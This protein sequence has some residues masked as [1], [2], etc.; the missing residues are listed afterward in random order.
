MWL[1]ILLFKKT[2]YFLS[3]QPFQAQKQ[4]TQLTVEILSEKNIDEP[5]VLGFFFRSTV[6]HHFHV[7][8][9]SGIG[10]VKHFEVV[11]RKEDIIFICGTA[12]EL[13]VTT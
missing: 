4:D 9:E 13:N 7:V 12:D 5:L 6:P 8:F 10:K 2:K 1:C 3:R 11:A